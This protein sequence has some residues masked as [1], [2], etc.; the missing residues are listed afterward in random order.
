MDTLVI[1]VMVGAVLAVGALGVPIAYAMGLCAI[2]GV[3]LSGGWQPALGLVGDAAFGSMREY[4]LV[5]IPLFDAMGF[6]VARSGAARDLFSWVNRHLGGMPAKFAVATVVGNAI[7]ATVTGIGAVAAVTFSR[8]AYPEMRRFGYDRGF[9]FGC[10]AGSSVLGLLLPPGIL[11]II[12]ALLTEQSVGELFLGAVV[13][14]LILASALA[15]YCV[16][17]A[18]WDPAVAPP[19]P[20]KLEGRTDVS[21]NR[22]P[23]TLSIVGIATLMVTVLGGIWGGFFTPAEASAFGLTGATLLALAKGMSWNAIL[24][25][26]LDSG[27]AVAPLLLMVIAAQMFS[28]MLAYEGITDQIEALLRTGGF[29]ATGTLLMMI[30]IWLLLG[31]MLDSVSIMLLTAP[32]FWPI[33]NSFGFDPIGFTLSAILIIEAGLLHPPF[34]MAVYLVKASIQ[35]DT[36]SLADGFWG[37]LP[38]CFVTLAVAILITI[39]PTLASWLPTHL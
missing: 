4:L 15:L 17:R 5:V 38:F 24:E 12:W 6:L 7:F 13:Q 32:I 16:G 9:A 20:P 30:F 2:G 18:L 31:S 14:C 28:R 26:L 33:A 25:T 27:K 3:A 8:I 35:D 21:P 29:E 37:T 19:T 22:R 34:G 36:I 39:F 11:L 10:V 23:E 1:S